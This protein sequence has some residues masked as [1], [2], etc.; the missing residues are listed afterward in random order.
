[1]AGRVASLHR[2]PIKG[3][4]PERLSQV[5]LEAGACFPVDRIFAVERGRCGFDPAA[6]Q[7]LS[8]WR[9]AVLANHARLAQ[10][11]TSYDE[12][13]GVLTVRLDGEPVLRAD[14]CDPAGR[15][16]FTTWLTRFLGEHE[17]ET[18]ALIDSGPAHRFTD[19]KEGAISIINLQSVRALE[20]SLGG[21]VDPLRMRANIY[22]EGWPAW[23][24]LNAPPGAVVRLGDVA[25][26]VVKPIPRCIAVH[27]DPVT[28]VRD[29][30]V[31]GAMR[32]D[33]GHV[34]CGLYVRVRQGGRL[35]EGDAALL[36]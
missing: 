11:V 8:K 20:A 3:F 33:F 6:P 29:L 25:C 4:T 23:A 32:R 12:D 15:G 22:V 19:D 14:L 30:D 2:H 10:A 31:L 28:G 13:T 17:D 27:V 35:A 26:E 36:P 5:R 9:F 24:E 34:N 7:H 16:A 21:A 18:L 1:M